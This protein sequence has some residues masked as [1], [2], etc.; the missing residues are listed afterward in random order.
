MHSGPESSKSPSV[1]PDA[2]QHNDHGKGAGPFV[3]LE[4]RYSL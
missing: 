1:P 4:Y 2:G 3:R